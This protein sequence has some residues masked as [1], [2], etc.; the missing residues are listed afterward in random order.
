[1][2]KLLIVFIA[3]TLTGCSWL[4]ANPHIDTL[5]IPPKTLD[6][7]SV[8]IIDNPTPTNGIASGETPILN[9]SLS[10]TEE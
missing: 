2:S 5:I 7:P 6:E 8:S 10:V 4:S 1:M 3:L 9:D